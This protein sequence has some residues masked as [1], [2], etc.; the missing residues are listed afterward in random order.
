MA[1]RRGLER[2][3]ER[4]PAR[5]GAD[6]DEKREHGADEEPEADP[7]AQASQRRRKWDAPAPAVREEV[8]R[9]DEEREEHR[10][11][12]ELDCPAAHDPLP[13]IDVARRPLG[14]VEPLVERAEQLLRRTADHRETCPVES[15]RR[16]A[17]RLGRDVARGRERDRRDSAREHR[18]L[19][20]ERVR[21]REGDQLLPGGRTHRRQPGLL[22]D[23]RR[24]GL[25]KGVGGGASSVRGD[26]EAGRPGA[27]DRV[28]ID[29]CERA[30]PVR[31]R[32]GELVRPD[33]AERA[34]VCRQEHEGVRRAHEGRRRRAGKRR[35][36]VR[37][38]QLDQRR[39]PGGVVVRARADPEVVA[40]RGDDDLLLRLAGDDRDEVLEL[41]RAE[42]GDRRPEALD[43]GVEPVRRELCLVPVRR[44]GVA[45]GS[46]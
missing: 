28:E 26:L 8:D 43:L 5:E 41:A 32:R 30:V 44:L 23:P 10:H 29:Q 27:G 4:H 11:E 6:Q 46:G 34:S 19:L 31:G 17:E 2:N 21:E 16:V 15:V 35:L 37:A 20:E 22:G 39:G 1:G 33:P 40:M 25:H 36:R 13:Q 14:E 9:R 7:A 3:R 38:G 12:H 18:A 42:P 45:L 24:S